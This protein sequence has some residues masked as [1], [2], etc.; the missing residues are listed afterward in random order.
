MKKKIFLILLII[1]SLTFS[2]SANTKKE[3]Y[4]LEKKLTPKKSSTATP[5]K[6]ALKPYIPL[7][8]LFSSKDISKAKY[9]AKKV[10]KSIYSDAIWFT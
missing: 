2:A 10:A 6:A 5:T 7:F 9:V 4:K 8:K 3:I 1:G